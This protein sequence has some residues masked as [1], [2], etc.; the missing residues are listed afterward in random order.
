MYIGL[1]MGASHYDYIMLQ[2]SKVIW[3]LAVIGGAHLFWLCP[4][5]GLE[6]E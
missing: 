2:I 3:F 6:T 5:V 4:N 1:F